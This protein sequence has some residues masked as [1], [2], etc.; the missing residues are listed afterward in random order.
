L[1]LRP[2][3]LRVGVEVFIQV[4]LPAQIC[5]GVGDDR[6]RGGWSGHGAL[7]FLRSI[8]LLA[9][10]PGGVFAHPESGW[11]TARTVRARAALV[12][13]DVA[14]CRGGTARPYGPG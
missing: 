13:V 4:L 10:S 2:R 9:G 7:T 5:R 6:A 14:P 11:S 3:E 12:L 1:L 8:L